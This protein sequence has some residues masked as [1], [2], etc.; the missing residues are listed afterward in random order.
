[1]PQEPHQQQQHQRTPTSS[2]SSS[3]SC[4]AAAGTAGTAGRPA[5]SSSSS[6]SIAEQQ[7]SSSIAHTRTVGFQTGRSGLRE[8]CY[9]EYLRIIFGTTLGSVSPLPI[10][11]KAMQLGLTGHM[12]WQTCVQKNGNLSAFWSVCKRDESSFYSGFRSA[13]KPFAIRCC[14]A[15]ANVLR[16]CSWCLAGSLP[17]NLRRLSL[18]PLSSTGPFS[19]TSSFHTILGARGRRHGR[20]PLQ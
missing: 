3:C 8:A 18:S 17:H 13:V 9:C 11:H 16:P 7:D 4:N 5:A 14:F 19:R 12:L 1:M 10:R 15:V 6:S 2:S 20:Q